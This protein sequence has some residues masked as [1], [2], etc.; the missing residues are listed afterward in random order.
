MNGSCY[1]TLVSEDSFDFRVHTS[2]YVDKDV[3]RDEMRNIFERSWVYVGHESELRQLGDYKTAAIGRQP[4]V[5]T[6][7]EDSNIHVLL[8]V[9]RHRGNVL[10][11]NEFGNSN[12]F[13]CAY[14]GWVYK[15]DGQLVGVPQKH[16]YDEE[17]LARIGGLA[18]AP[19]VSS[20]RGFL[21][22]NLSADGPTLDEYLGE[23]KK[24]VDLW[25]DMAPEGKLQV[26]KPHK[27]SY[28]GN[29]K[30]QAE[31]GIDGYHT[32]Y[33]HESI[34]KTFEHFNVEHY[35]TT[36]VNEGP[37]VREVGCTRGFENGHCLL[38]RPGLRVQVRPELFEVYRSS[39]L[40][41][42]GKERTDQ[43][44]NV[45]HIFIFPNLYLMDTNL[46]VIQPIS[47]NETYVYSH[48]FE[49]GG[50]PPEINRER[51]FS[52]QKRLGT[53]GFFSSDDMEMFV[54]VQS[55]VQA[56]NMQWVVLSRGLNREVVLANG[57]RLGDP[58]DETPQRAIYRGW[59]NFMNGS[60][61]ETYETK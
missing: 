28:P 36:Q 48:F 30:L 1:G 14:H 47:V 37:A 60:R 15:N 50:A 10:C 21:F 46:R 44:L 12:F 33:A 2:V 22:A 26:S 53:A 4:V 41:R 49:L 61:E 57:E 7:S 40:E 34:L 52:L 58:S 31:N 20:Y 38:E 32:R 51:F 24:Y 29:W 23:V 19:R 18:K 42:Y 6:R 59:L 5:V 16:R 27:Y 9:C 25:I 35:G 43:I 13:R 11:R 45:R 3:F 54:G 55:G 8:N 17:F 56:A 39:L